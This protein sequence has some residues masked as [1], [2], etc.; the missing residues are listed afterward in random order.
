MPQLHYFF[1][2]GGTGGH[3]YPAIAV[4]EQ[5]KRDQPEAKITFFC[6]G[7]QIDSRILARTD[8]EYVALPARGFSARPDKF[9]AFCTSFWKSYTLAHRIIADSQPSVLLGIGGFVSAPVVAAA[10]RLKV[11][12]SLLNLDIV[13]GR[14]NKLL[15]RYAKEIYVQFGETRDCFRVSRPGWPCLQVFTGWKPVPQTV[16]VTGC[17]LRAEFLGPNPQRARRVLGLDENKKV[18][19]ITGGSSGAENVNAAVCSVL[20]RLARFVNEWQIV[21]LAGPAVE[22]VKR[23]YE[24]TKLNYKVLYYFDDMPDLLAAANLVLGRAGAVSVAE[25]AAAGVPSICLP[26]PYHKDRHQYLN[27]EKLVQAGCAVIVEDLADRSKTAERLAA[28][29]VELMGNEA[30]RSEMSQACKRIA[31]LDAAAEIARGI[32]I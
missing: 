26:Y 8:Y 28:E 30:R 19:L 17:P 23:E 31:K 6:S 15:A 10:H 13:P 11:P 27:A 14:A 25:Y 32:S 24:K 7:R 12:V 22:S 1:A 29:L 3:I 4:A 16:I 9:I 21:H 5:I 20:D 18:L 2:G